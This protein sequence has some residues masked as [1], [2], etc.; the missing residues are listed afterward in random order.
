MKPDRPDIAPWQERLLTL[1]RR[2]TIALVAGIYC[3]I[4]MGLFPPWEQLFVNE[5]GYWYDR[6]AGFNF[7]LSPPDLY[8][9]PNYLGATVNWTQ[10]FIQW[11]LTAAIAMG[12]VWRFRDN[13]HDEL[14][15]R[16]RHRPPTIYR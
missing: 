5:L 9:T 2:Q 7:V 10:L 11:I 13:L 6:P 8:N 1:N 4:M 12:V 14:V 16:P 3:F 15:P